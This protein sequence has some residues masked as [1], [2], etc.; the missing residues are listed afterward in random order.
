MPAGKAVST[1]ASPS[2]LWGESPRRVDLDPAK[3]AAL[4]PAEQKK[5][6]EAAKAERDQLGGEIE[7]RLEV[8]DGK[9]KHSRLSTRTDALREYHERGGRLDGRSR[10]RLDGLLARSEASQRKI[11]ELRAKADALPKTP[12]AK[13]EMAALR[14]ELARELRRARDEQSKVVKE[15]TEVVDEAGLKTDRLVV[16]EQII[17]PTAPAP[18]SGDSLLEKVAR[19]FG[20]DWF[21]SSSGAGFAI[22]Q[23]YFAKS[24]DERVARL[25][26]EGKVALNQKIAR[27]GAKKERV[28]AEQAARSD[29]AAAEMLARVR[30]TLAPLSAPGTPAPSPASGA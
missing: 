6:V 12:E 1:S 4:S 16:T 8:L 3:F 19:F 11:N 24:V 27:D 28:S 7:A 22:M 18:G 26:E 2:A 17:D 30:A 23:S 20:L 9:W 29:D 21:L 5:T 15:A 10:R 25:E 14:S 13:K